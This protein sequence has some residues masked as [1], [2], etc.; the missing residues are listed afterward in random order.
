MQ[1]YQD[2]GELLQEVDQGIRNLKDTYSAAAKDE[3]AKVV[4]RPLIK[5]CLEHLRSCLEYSAQ[6]I[7]Q[8]KIGGQK[9][10]YFPYGENEKKF[11]GSVSNNLPGIEKLAPNIY[12]LIA[13]IQP[14]NCG[15]DWLTSLCKHA[16]FNK[17]NGLSKP[18][19]VN[20]PG[21]TTSIG[22]L[23][24]ISGNA[25]MTMINCSVNG[26]PIGLERPLVLSG[27][28]TVKEM[29]NEL[30]GFITVSRQFDWVEFRFPGTAIDTVALIEKSHQFIGQ[31]VAQLYKQ[32]Q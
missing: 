12:K 18:E 1:R 7:F 17:H 32:L 9:S 22:G 23:A 16:N 29:Q 4:N 19:R 8:K 5:S 14:F 26:V 15:D 20:S 28:R 27:Q 11:I 30:P 25:S 3:Y 2:I 13:E 6:D 31:F 21:S 10:P 24:E